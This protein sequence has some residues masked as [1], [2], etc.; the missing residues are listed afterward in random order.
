MKLI[1]FLTYKQ[2]TSRID[3]PEI[4][5]KPFIRLASLSDKNTF[6]L[7]KPEV[8]QNVHGPP[9]DWKN[10]TEIDFASVYI[11]DARKD[12]AASIN[13]ALAQGKHLLLSPGVYQL[14]AALRVSAPGAVVLGL[15][16]AT[17]R[18]TH[19]TPAMLVAAKSC[20]IAG[21]L[22]DAGSASA[23]VSPQLLLVEKGKSTNT[24]EEPTV[25][26]DIFARVG[27]R[28]NQA[29]VDT[30]VTIDQVNF[31]VLLLLFFFFFFLVYFSKC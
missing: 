16:L 17:L 8:R 29:V 18:P 6:V 15:G 11:A 7:A 25:L 14:D 20:R 22:F 1:Q 23:P 12:T 30:M 31:I 3:T 24:P 27:G 10:V 9:A 26:S 13:K 28:T 19:G 5:A 4:A 21:V 2:W